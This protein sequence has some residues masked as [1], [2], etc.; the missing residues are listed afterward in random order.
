M[1]ALAS[2]LEN[3]D[4]FAK[5]YLLSGFKY[6]FDIGF[7]GEPNNDINVKNLLSTKKFPLIVSDA[8][9]KEVKAG[10][11]SGPFSHPPF[12][13][14]Q[15]SP[16]GVVPKKTEG[17]FRLI[18]NLSSPEAKSINDH[19]PDFFSEVKYAPLSDAIDLLLKCGS[20]AFLAKTDIKSAFRIIPIKPDQHHLLCMSW[21]NAFYFD[22]CLPMGARSSCQIFESFSSA[23][24]FI[25]IDK[26]INF[27]THYLD[28]FLIV[29]NSKI[30]GLKDLN[31][32]VD[33][34]KDIG[35]PLSNEKTIL[36]TQ[37]IDY[38]GFEINTVN[39]TI[40]LPSDKLLKCKQSIYDL[41]NKKNSKCTLKE[42]QSLLGLLNFA[43]TVIIPG[44]AFLQRLYHLTIGIRKPHFYITITRAAKEDL[45]LWLEFLSE[46]NGISLY[47]E[48]MFLNPSIFQ[49][50]TDA[51]QSLGL[52]AVFGK[53]WFYQKWPSTWWNSQNITFLE[54]VP[55]VLALQ[56]WGHIL[57]NGYVKLL[58]DNEAL[59][60]S[61]N[62][63]S[64][65]EPLVMSW[66]RKLV[67]LALRFN[68]VIKA[69]HIPGQFN[70]QSDSLS[71]LQ[72]HR[73]KMLHPTADE[74][75]TKNPPLPQ[76]AT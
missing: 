8:I 22:K 51:S 74:Q 2:C 12:P 1:S 71:R 58:T 33:T 62:K 16:I 46:Y 6:G 3:Y 18:F 48:Q 14:F 37:I 40:S 4:P 13:K 11:L 44:R 52:G 55:I 49:I 21:N 42:L 65:K 69:F 53:H 66:I 68:V 75:P 73:F 26:R 61:I 17:K 38:L 43:C 54:L 23:L 57:S 64:S 39:E 5:A 35:I 30:N 56:V 63:Q 25:A 67:L 36:P 9:A 59:S 34:C 50:C 31:K 24:Q 72:I 76:F 19:I 20:H 41:I 7:R 32:F 29:N 60:F 10:R 27:I 15:I 47:R 45:S 70:S 28:D